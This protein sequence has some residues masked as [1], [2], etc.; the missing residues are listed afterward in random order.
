MA[1]QDRRGYRKS[2]KDAVSGGR[3]SGARVRLLWLALALAAACGRTATVESGPAA[4]SGAAEVSVSELVAALTTLQI[5]QDEHYAA[6]GAYTYELEA[7]DFAPPE[8]VLI[9]VLEVSSA[10]FSAIA[11]SADGERECGIYVG[12]VRAPRSY[13]DRA[14]KAVCR[15]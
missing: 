4:G 10:G 11:T 3:Q 8:G 9:D 1:D 15:P 5:R 6:N 7:L 2:R 13:V 14:A 12:D